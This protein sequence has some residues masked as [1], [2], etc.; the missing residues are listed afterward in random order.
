[1]EYATFSEGGDVV[2][3][4]THAM[5][6]P[7]KERDDRIAELEAALWMARNRLVTIENTLRRIS[8]ND[9]MRMIEGLTTLLGDD[10]AEA[11]RLEGERTRAHNAARRDAY[12][13]AYRA[14][15]DRLI[16]AG[17]TLGMMEMR[18][19]AHEKGVEAAQK[20]GEAT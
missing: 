5:K 7:I 8:G 6:N 12:D 19:A 13:T 3:E 18:R 4:F 9:S 11:R 15:V 2:G 14:E 16:D 1:M 17:S 10:S 20:V